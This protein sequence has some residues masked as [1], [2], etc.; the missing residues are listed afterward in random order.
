MKKLIISAPFGNWLFHPEAT[1]TLG[2]FTLYHR[3]GLA[4]RLWRCALT[5]RYFRRAQAWINKLGLPNP[6]LESL[7]TDNYHYDK[8]VSIH[9]F[10]EDEWTSM[11]GSLAHRLMPEAVELNLSCPNVGQHGQ[12]IAAVFPAINLLKDAEIKI[13]AKLPPVQWLKLALPL[14]DLGVRAFHCCNTIPTPGGGLSGK[15]LKQYS[16][17]CVEDLRARFGAEVDLIGGGGITTPQ[18]IDDYRKAGA[19]RVAVGSYLISPFYRS[20][21]EA[22]TTA[23]NSIFKE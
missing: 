3:G 2:T 22:L 15:V 1:S 19:N 16:L 20:R 23:A 13:I 7:P 17:W 14:Y 9:G 6:G 10:A 12:T 4:Y 18:D 11:A 21:L 5:L 8:I